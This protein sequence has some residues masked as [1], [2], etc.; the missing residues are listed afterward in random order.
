MRALQ[1]GERLLEG[2]SGS[3]A[4][5]SEQWGGKVFQGSGCFL[6]LLL[7]LKPDPSGGGVAPSPIVAAAAV[8]A[9][10]RVKGSAASF[11][12]A[13]GLLLCAV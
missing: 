2:S 9:R 12:A 13:Q 10:G 4:K 8:R 5:A 3:Q 6:G 7:T 11:E 1:Q